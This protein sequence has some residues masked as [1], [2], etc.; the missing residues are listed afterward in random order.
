M[1]T[2]INFKFNLAVR[3]NKYNLHSIKFIF[4]K[5]GI[6]YLSLMVDFSDHQLTD[7]NSY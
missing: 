3:F 2:F 5:I 1:C 6:V 4:I 7:L